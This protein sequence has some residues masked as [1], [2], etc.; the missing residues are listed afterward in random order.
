[1][2]R[3]TSHLALVL[4]FIGILCSFLSCR[5]T[6]SNNK[7]EAFLGKWNY[8]TSGEGY[9]GDTIEDGTY[10]LTVTGVQI[11]KSDNTGS[12]TGNFSSNYDVTID[13]IPVT[14]EVTGTLQEEANWRIEG[15]S[16]IEENVSINYKVHS[17]K[18]FAFNNQTNEKID[19]SD[20]DDVQERIKAL[21]EGYE[22][23]MSSTGERSALGITSI[24]PNMIILHDDEGGKA[25]LTRIE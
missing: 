24:K 3:S 5:N 2:K 16:L 22:E 12:L 4:M 9:V 15:D 10:S 7:E 23:D 11:Y 20:Y 6:A 8:S 19:V 13:D 25:K 14:F 21:K 1:M 18:A 17:V